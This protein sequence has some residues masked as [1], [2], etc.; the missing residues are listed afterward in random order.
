MLAHPG[1][2]AYFLGQPLNPY[3]PGE[4]QGNICPGEPGYIAP[5]P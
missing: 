1:D 5:T 2:P 3:E 4:L